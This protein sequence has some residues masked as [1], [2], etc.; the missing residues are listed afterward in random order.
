MKESSHELSHMKDTSHK[1]LKTRVTNLWIHGTQY[2]IMNHVTCE[3]VFSHIQRSRRK[4]WVTISS[5]HESRTLNTVDHPI[6]TYERHESRTLWRHESQ[7]LWGH[8]SRFLSRHY[9]RY[10]IRM[11]H[12]LAKDM[13][14]ELFEDTSHELFEDMRHNPFQDT[15]CDAT[16][17]C[18]IN[19]RKTWVTNSVKIRVTDSLRTL[20]P[21]FEHL[22]IVYE[23]I[24]SHIRDMSHE[25]FEDMNHQFFEKMFNELSIPLR[26]RVSRTNDMSH[27]LFVWMTDI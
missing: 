20:I 4:M 11:W 26:T 6:I 27:E 15:M 1:L 17:V 16:F 23:W 22:N 18:D 2:Q 21:I 10:L 8:V 24:M 9:V 19:R 25:L 5:R 13:G 12:E 3:S 14:H 7:T